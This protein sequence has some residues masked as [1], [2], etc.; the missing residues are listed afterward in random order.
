MRLVVYPMIYKVF[1]HLRWCR[2]S[3]INSSEAI[4]ESKVWCFH[5]EVL[6]EVPFSPTAAMPIANNMMMEDDKDDNG[7]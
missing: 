1:I 6:A 7:G 5:H 3:A 4:R 2:I